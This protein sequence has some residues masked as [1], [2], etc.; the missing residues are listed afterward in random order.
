MDNKVMQGP[1]DESN[2]ALSQSQRAWRAEGAWLRDPVD[3]WR[4]Q[5]CQSSSAKL[6][7][8]EEKESRALH[9]P[10]VQTWIQPGLF[11]SRPNPTEFYL[12]FWDMHLTLK[13]GLFL[14][15]LMKIMWYDVTDSKWT[16]DCFI[17]YILYYSFLRDKVIFLLLT[18]G[19]LI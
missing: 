15:L 12:K 6:I 18:K 8:W 4:L 1:Q 2:T 13:Q 11:N 5:C 16:W 9:G 17:T 7:G 10:K 19:F 3:R 14:H